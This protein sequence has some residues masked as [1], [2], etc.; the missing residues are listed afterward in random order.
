MKYRIGF[1]NTKSQ[2]LK[3]FLLY[4]FLFSLF[5]FIWFLDLGSWIFY[6]YVFG[7]SKILGSTSLLNSILV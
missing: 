7:I 6:V 3:L 2:R 1:L 4:S 5:F